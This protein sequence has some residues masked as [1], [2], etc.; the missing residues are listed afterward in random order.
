[1]GRYSIQA[2]YY[3]SLACKRGYSLGA[4]ATPDEHP[5][6]GWLL[7]VWTS[8][9]VLMLFPTAAG[10]ASRVA[11]DRNQVNWSTESPS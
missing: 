9:V 10:E 2:C 8:F 3:S 6:S 11:Y 1:M 7:P 5:V 4:E